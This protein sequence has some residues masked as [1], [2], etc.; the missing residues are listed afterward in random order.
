MNSNQPTRNFDRTDDHHDY[1]TSQIESF[2]TKSI[3]EKD[4]SSMQSTDVSV[5]CKR[6]S[7]INSKEISHLFRCG[8]F[9]PK[10]SIILLLDL[11]LFS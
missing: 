8:T 3:S 6:D 5:S 1:N 11:L 7:I 10:A 9:V 2:S 4:I